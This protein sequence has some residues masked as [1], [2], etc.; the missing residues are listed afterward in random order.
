VSFDD[1]N[2]IDLSSLLP[3]EPVDR[4]NPDVEPMPRRCECGE[5]V[6]WRWWS[7]N[8]SKPSHRRLSGRWCP[9]SIDPC[10]VCQ[11]DESSERL[12]LDALQ[13]DA[14]K[15]ADVPLRLRHY[16]L[17]WTLLQA[18]GE[19]D[20]EFRERVARSVP[21]HVGVTAG[22]MKAAF[23]LR[24]WRPGNGSV[25]L[26]GPV[27]TGK[28]LLL[29]AFA[30]GLMRVTPPTKARHRHA[31]AWLEGASVDAR[32]Y[33]ETRGLTSTFSAE[34]PMATVLYTTAKELAHREGLSWKGDPTPAFY[35]AKIDVLIIDELAASDKIH[36][37]EQNVIERVVDY[38]YKNNLPLV[39]AT[40]RD[41]DEL[42]DERNGPYGARMSDRLAEMFAGS[43]FLVGGSSWRRPAKP[44]AV[45]P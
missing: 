25:L 8:P 34:R 20:A 15:R 36:T 41:Y 28:T 40:N 26:H 4:R 13:T 10:H 6:G 39:C 18:K 45:I 14:M 1:D 33:A 19:A 5:L 2:L 31:D 27:G 37:A 35:S 44:T 21:K 38:R 12:R 30:R 32:A 42:T 16:S 23:T 22:N 24:D 11:P 29:C 43:A 7:P 9:D 17:N 3:V